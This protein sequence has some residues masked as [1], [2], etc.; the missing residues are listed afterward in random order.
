MQIDIKWGCEMARRDSFRN[1]LL[2]ALLL[3]AAAG[4]VAGC[5]SSGS[6]AP[7][8]SSAAA[9]P[10]PSLGGAAATAA[11]TSDW[12]AFFNKA[13]P[14]GQKSQYLQNGAQ[15]SSVIQ[16][17][18][19]NPLTGEVTAKVTAVKFTSPT[20]ATVTYDIDGPAGTPLLSG[21]TGTAVLQNGTWV[22]SDASLCGLLTL[23]GT[24]VA[25]CSS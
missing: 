12:E 8:A 19:S 21:S 2:G 20:Q 1:T 13:T 11:V 24:S 10:S 6:A 17:F 3:L 14:L 7:A 23:T 15:M 16:Q 9:S 18:S 22:V 5:S 25:G 4:P